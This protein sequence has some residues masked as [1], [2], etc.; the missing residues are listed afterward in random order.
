LPF[1]LPEALHEV[2]KADEGYVAARGVLTFD[3]RKLP[4]VD[5]NNQADTPALTRIKARLKGTILTKNGFSKPLNTRLTLEIKCF[6][7][8]CAGA[9]SG[10][11]VLA[12]LEQTPTGY[13]LSTTPCGGHIFGEPTRANIKAVEQCY[14]KG[15]CPKSQN[16]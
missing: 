4:K 13:S 5:W 8:W 3:E 15:I 12:F 1:G 7:P 6:G 11:E 16:H 2:I 9:T 14:L 10:I